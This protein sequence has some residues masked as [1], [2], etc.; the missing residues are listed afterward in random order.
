MIQRQLEGASCVTNPS[1]EPTVKTAPKKN[2]RPLRYPRKM[3]VQQTKKRK[4]N[5]QRDYS[6]HELSRKIQT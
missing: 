5:K 6:P 4:E 3:E 1:S 2:L